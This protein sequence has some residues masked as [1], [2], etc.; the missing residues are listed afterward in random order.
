MT[1]HPS[2]WTY[3][4]FLAYLLLYAAHSDTKITDQEKEM[5]FARAGTHNYHHVK[6]RFDHANDYER[7]QVIL[8]FRESYFPDDYSKNKLL[9]DM[10]TL[11][12]SDYEYSVVEKSF[13]MCIRRL[14][15]G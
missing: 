9:D 1:T 14:L 7:L 15:A 10:Y 13:F 11:L 2:D 3:N 5:I 8:G 4:Q 6:T 12:L